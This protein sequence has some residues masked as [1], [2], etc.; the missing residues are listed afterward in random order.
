MAT[1]S[2]PAATGDNRAIRSPKYFP[3]F[4]PLFERFCSMK[5]ENF[6][7]LTRETVG[8]PFF[9]AGTREKMSF[10]LFLVF[11]KQNAL[12]YARII[13]CNKSVYI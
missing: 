2:G 8:A 4:P 10:F 9:V 12:I 7:A 11:Y 1:K 3:S 5:L 6:L 13:L